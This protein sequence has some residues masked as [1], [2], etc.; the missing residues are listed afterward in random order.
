[1]LDRFNQGENPIFS[2]MEINAYRTKEEDPYIYKNFKRLKNEEYIRNHLD[3]KNHY[4]IE[5]LYIGDF[6]EKVSAL[7][8]DHYFPEGYE[9][10]PFYKKVNVKNLKLGQINQDKYIVLKIVSELYKV[11]AILFLGEDEDKNI[12]KI[13]IYNY[14]SYYK[15]NKEEELQKI[16]DVGKYIIC[17]NSFYKVYTSKDDGLRIESPAEIILLNDINE[18]NYFFERNN[19]RNI[20]G[21]KELGNF[22]MQK[23]VYE[24]AIY[25]YSESISM[26]KKINQN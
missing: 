7:N 22:F 2:N 3:N 15:T 10:L 13:S 12:L 19:N 26:I 6:Y 8:I 23:M 4:Q 18:L 5:K 14:S 1:M 24:K 17:I 11:K 16:F 25:Y 21:L 20:I 9:I